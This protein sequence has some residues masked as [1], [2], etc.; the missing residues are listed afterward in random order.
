MYFF[1][2]LIIINLLH[3]DICYSS[4]IAKSTLVDVVRQSGGE[5]AQA[6]LIGSLLPVILTP[7]YALFL[8]SSSYQAVS[9]LN[10]LL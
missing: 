2:T 5:R 7:N 10:M 3:I 1:S 4:I 6:L 9:F 8:L